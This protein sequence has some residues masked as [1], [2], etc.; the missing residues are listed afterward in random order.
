MTVTPVLAARALA[1]GR[2]PAAVLT[3]V[4]LDVA[5]GERVALVG[6]NGC[7]KTTLLRCFAGLDAPR[8]G[9]LTWRGAQ[10][11]RGPARL[12]TVGVLLQDEAAPAFSVTE[13]CTLGLGLDGPPGPAAQRTVAACLAQLG[14]THLAAR[15]CSS[16]SGGEAR[17]AAL[18]RAIVAEPALL[19]LDE[20]TNHLDPAHQAELLAWLDRARD[21]AVAVVLATHDLT[22][23]SVCD[24]VLLLAD[25]RPLA[26]G[27]PEDVLT[28][29]LLERA[30]GVRV[31]RVEDPEGGPPFLRVVAPSPRLARSAA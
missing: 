5:A 15:R 17:R 29:A 14:L 1:V 4:D 22:V 20:P 3:H 12:S 23:A 24:R 13:L 6:G 27:A 28:P 21:S 18:A 10:L 25:H 8:A 11:A 31:R 16:L 9:H 19:L 26:L 30:L 2:G 7:G